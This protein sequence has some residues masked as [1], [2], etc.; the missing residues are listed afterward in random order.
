MCGIAGICQLHKQSLA[1]D[2][3]GVLVNAIRHRGPDGEGIWLNEAKNLALGHR[4]L[5]ILDLSEAGRQP[6]SYLSG[7]YQM[8]FNGEIYNFLE[9]KEELMAAGCS[10]VSDSDSEVL[11]AAYDKWGESMLH[12]LNGMW[13]FALYNT[14]DDTLWLSRDRFGVKPLYYCVHNGDFMFASEVQAIHKLLGTDAVL[15][16]AV[17]RDTATG[18]FVSHGSDQTY[19]KNVSSLPAGCNLKVSQGNIEISRWYK[20]P[21]IE[22][23][24]GLPA[25]A[26]KLKELLFDACKIRLRSDVPVGTCLS[27]GVDSGS[28]T[29]IINQFKPAAGSRE[30][31]Y[32]H[33]GF[34]AAF[35]GAAINEVAAAE[36]LAGQT[37]SKLDVVNIEA[38][39]VSE[40]EEAM[41][42]CD[43]PMHALAFFPIWQL[44]R[45][46]K[47]A[48]V[49]VTLDGQ[50]PDE[51]LGGYR[52]LPE[53]LI[54][55]LQL[56]K[57]SWFKD[58][59]ETYAGQGEGEQMSSRNFARGVFKKL[60]I[61]ILKYYGK[62]IL[63]AL[64]LYHKPFHLKDNVVKLN[65]YLDESLYDQFFR[66]PLP[67]ILNQY[68]RCSMASGVEC[69]MP[70]MDYR[71]VEFVF[72]LPPESKVGGGYTK[73]V[74]REAMAGVLP[75]E[76]R[77]NK[78]KIGFNAPLVEWF[79]G[80]LREF[81][82]REMSNTEFLQNKYFD[83]Q[84]IKNDFAAFLQTDRP[85]WDAAWAFWPPVHLS[86]WLR[87]NK[88][89]QL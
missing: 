53:A 43:G 51:M 61:Y 26:T 67:G 85:Q 84:K 12:K 42:A 1:P 77:L 4:R 63:G 74:L 11:M 29:A 15:N 78:T 33:R 6:M 81:M 27:G 68:D 48:G 40:L 56:G 10:F 36:K 31:N 60:P 28:I 7:K 70:F 20:L 55:A 50:G 64:G 8:V 79:R 88:I 89:K 46:I 49:T 59:Y 54:A 14:A 23:P 3:I 73:R 21:K 24:M 5:S 39:T 37:G 62:K 2:K 87:N 82:L 52:P 86:W 38:P 83:G 80:P 57:P 66:S 44:Y 9:I 69:R 72:S 19:L 58:V 25:Q 16:D 45:H 22:V 18:G 32:V 65:N 17:I 47:A 35:P 75:D 76:I 41:R 34:C 13:V 30:A 71:I